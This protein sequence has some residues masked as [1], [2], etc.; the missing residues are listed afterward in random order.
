VDDSSNRVRKAIKVS[1]LLG[2]TFIADPAVDLPPTPTSTTSIDLLN[3]KGDLPRIEIVYFIIHEVYARMSG[4]TM[5]CDSDILRRPLHLL[6]CTY[7]VRKR[8]LHQPLHLRK[9][10]LGGGCSHSSELGHSSHMCSTVV[11]VRSCGWRG[12]RVGDLGSCQSNNV[13]SPVRPVAM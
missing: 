1:N 4:N 3:P 12:W 8:F 9:E 5:S 10:I 7:P 6:V 2:G 13:A 11:M